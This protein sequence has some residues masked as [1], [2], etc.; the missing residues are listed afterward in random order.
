MAEALR[1][2]APSPALVHECVDS[3]LV[4]VPKVGGHADRAAAPRRA[5]H[6]GERRLARPASAFGLGLE[7]G[8]V[9][10]QLLQERHTSLKPRPSPPSVL[11]DEATDAEVGVAEQI[12]LRPEARRLPVTVLRIPVLEPTLPGNEIPLP[13]CTIFFPGGEG[14]RPGGPTA[15]LGSARRPGGSTGTPYSNRFFLILTAFDASQ[16]STLLEP[17]VIVRLVAKAVL[18]GAGSSS[19]ER[20][21]RGLGGC[22]GP[23]A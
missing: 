6:A 7:P 13:E 23:S 12:A 18:L 16:D 1:R 19:G 20:G 2:K 15:S 3:H 9:L 5:R 11:G 14:R 22:P 17:D 21:S 10:S 8:N 4:K